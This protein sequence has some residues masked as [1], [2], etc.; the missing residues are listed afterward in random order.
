MHGD[1]SGL[2]HTGKTPAR[3]RSRRREIKAKSEKERREKIIPR[4]IRNVG[5]IEKEDKTET[6]GARERC[7][8]QDKEAK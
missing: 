2:R 6:E 3:S 7:K 5:E 4:R 8:E 1:F